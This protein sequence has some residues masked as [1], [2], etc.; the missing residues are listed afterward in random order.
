MKLALTLLFILP[1]PMAFSTEKSVQCR[2]AVASSEIK[3]DKGLDLSLI[4]RFMNQPPPTGPL[5]RVHDAIVGRGLGAFTDA[6]R[7]V[8]W[9][10]TQYTHEIAAKVDT[11]DNSGRCWI[12]AGGN[13]IELTTGVKISK[14]HLHFMRMME[15]AHRNIQHMKDLRFNSQNLKNATIINMLRNPVFYDGGWFTDFHYLV[16]KYGVVPEIAMPETFTSKNTHVLLAELTDYMKI[17]MFEWWQ[18]TE[19]MVGVPVVYNRDME[20][21]FKLMNAKAATKLPNLTSAQKMEMEAFE[22]EILAGVWKILTAHLGVPPRDFV[23]REEGKEGE[24]PELKKMTPSNFLKSLNF[25]PENFVAVTNLINRPRNSLIMVKY[26][27]A[28]MTMKMLNL[29]PLRIAEIVRDMI[30]NKIPVWFAADVSLHVDYKTGIM[31][32]AIKVTDDIYG[33]QGEQVARKLTDSE[34]QFLGLLQTNHAMVLMGV[35]YVR[36][37]NE[38]TGIFRF[39][40]DKGTMEIVK[41]KVENSWSTASGDNGLYHMYPEW[42]IKYLHQAIVPA[43]YLN[44]SEQKIWNAPPAIR[45]K[46]TED[47]N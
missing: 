22:K 5:Q 25:K 38:T 24:A 18:R 40:T 43:S 1:A 26:T 2:L 3:V 10:N 47:F 35:D 32:P 29:E 36:S 21:R 15:E 37:A 28:P 31:H 41:F 44:A 8:P 19:K 23:V 33:H 4:E 34:S 39:Q 16:K 46:P 17:Q 6:Q 27:D 45:I 7:T 30:I 20:T 12:F 13:I 11:Q 42:F 14:T 9:H